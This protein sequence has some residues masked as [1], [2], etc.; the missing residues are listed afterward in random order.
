MRTDIH[1][2]NE[3]KNCNKYDDDDNYSE[4]ENCD[5]KFLMQQR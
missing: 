5:S 2:K 3:D 4:C 1:T